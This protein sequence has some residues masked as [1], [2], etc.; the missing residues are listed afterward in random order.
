MGTDSFIQD[1]TSRFLKLHRP[2]SDDESLKKK[3]WKSWTFEW[4]LVVWF[5]AGKT[6]FCEMKVTIW[7][8]KN[9]IEASTVDLT[10]EKS[11]LLAQQSAPNDLINKVTSFK[12]VINRKLF[13]RMARI[14]RLENNPLN[15]T[16]KFT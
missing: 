5:R 4:V 12:F 1:S 8:G 6:N 13:V 11:S 16:G 15:E 2:M 3:N 14:F 9:Q 10:K 7:A